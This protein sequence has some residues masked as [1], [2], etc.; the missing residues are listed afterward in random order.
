LGYR[1]HQAVRGCCQFCRLLEL[2]G[3]CKSGYQ[4]GLVFHRHARGEGTAGIHDRTRR[5]AQVEGVGAKDPLRQFVILGG[6]FQGRALR[7]CQAQVATGEDLFDYGFEIVHLPK[8]HSGHTM[9]IMGTETAMTS[10][11]SGRPMRQ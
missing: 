5:I 3:P 4:V 7:G 10:T 1:V 6:S 9:R 8:P 2:A 11:S